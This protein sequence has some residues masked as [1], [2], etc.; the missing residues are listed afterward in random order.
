M[1][2]KRSAMYST[3][4]IITQTAPAS[5]LCTCIVVSYLL[6][7][8]PSAQGA[9][10]RPIIV[11]QQGRRLSSIYYAVPRSNVP[12]ATAK[13][14][15]PTLC[16]GDKTSSL[17]EKFFSLFTLPVVKAQSCSQTP[18]GGHYFYQDYEDCPP[19]CVYLYGVVYADSSV[20]NYYKGYRN[21]NFTDCLSPCQICAIRTCDL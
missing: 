13:Q 6:V 8:A 17:L 10:G 9:I 11:D 5:M 16:S 14:Q 2:R 18:C 15:T 1:I 21:E 3:A 19:A 20:G 4:R 12:K 7:L